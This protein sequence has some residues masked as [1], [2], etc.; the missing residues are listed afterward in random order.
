MVD[1]LL[2]DGAASKLK[3]N[4]HP[5]SS[6]I[7]ALLERSPPRDETTARQWF[8]VLS[9]RVPGTVSQPSL[10]LETTSP[11]YVC[12]ILSDRIT[13]AVRDTIRSRQ[14]CWR[15]GYTPEVAT[16]PVLLLWNRRRRAAF[17]ALFFR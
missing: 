4:S 3:L 13:E 16:Y 15:Q 11:N 8:E 1:P 10:V 14:V 9:G 17:E 12:R 7:V 5:P 6:E 2:P